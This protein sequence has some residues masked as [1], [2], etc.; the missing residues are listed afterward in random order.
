MK[1][2]I[3]ISDTGEEEIVIRC[4]ERN[5]TIALLEKTVEGIVR[6]GGELTLYLDSTEFYVPKEDILFFESLDGKVYAHTADRMFVTHMKLFE[7][8]DC[9]P[10]YFV[11]IA[12]STVA[13]CKRISALRR[14][15]MGNG[16]IMFR[17]SDKKA[18]FSRNYYKILKDKIDEIRFSK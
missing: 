2:R 7:V 1:I 12:K 4:R 6:G 3:E 13:N 18:Y 15:I 14:E 17:H 9:M 16:E 8:E 10:S 11:R 5:E